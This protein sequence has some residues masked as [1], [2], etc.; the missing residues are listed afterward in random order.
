M[1]KYLIHY[2]LATARDHD[3]DYKTL[4]DTIKKQMPDSHHIPES[5]WIGVSA[6]TLPDIKL[7]LRIALSKDAGD[8]LVIF[9]LAGKVVQSGLP[10]EVASWLASNFD[11]LTEPPAKA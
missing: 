10:K 11:L 3:R 8:S 4:Q 1:N 2:K 6:H 5:T 9:Q 7:A